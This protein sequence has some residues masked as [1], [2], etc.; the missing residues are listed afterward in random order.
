LAKRKQIIVGSGTAAL[1]SL[2]QIR[3]AGCDDEVKLFTMEEHDP[4]SP[5][6]LPYVL[7]G[8]LTAGQIRMVP[9]GFFDEMDATLIKGR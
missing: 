1:N 7:L 8:K 3:K 2:R 5:M 9:D 4:Y 6:S